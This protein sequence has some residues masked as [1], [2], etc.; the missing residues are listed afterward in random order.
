MN[1]SKLPK[2]IL[3]TFAIGCGVYLIGKIFQGGFDYNSINE[4]FI[5]FSI[6]QLYAFVLGMSNTFYFD[7]IETR[8]WKKHDTI[9]R[10]LIGIV[11]SVTITLVGLFIVRLIVS[12]GYFGQ[13]FGKFMSGH[14]WE[15]YSF[16]F[17]ITL[18]I[19]TIFQYCLFLQ[20]L[21]EKP[22]KG[23]DYYSRYGER[24]I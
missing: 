8:H 1:F 15:Y 24:E 19:F 6:W 13:P 9:K 18:I 17:W 16:G 7:Y 21:S 20:S 22:N 3:I 2:Q 4:F 23:T 14:R 5:D 12:V 11:G 10:I